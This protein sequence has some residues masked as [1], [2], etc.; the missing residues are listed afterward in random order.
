MSDSYEIQGVKITPAAGGYYDIEHVS[1]SEPERVRGKEKADARAAEIAKAAEA[2]E[3]SMPP[4]GELTT[5]VGGDVIQPGDT[6]SPAE[7]VQERDASGGDP[8]T[9]PLKQP[10]DDG[11]TNSQIKS[12]KAEETRQ[13]LTGTPGVRQAASMGQPT[14]DE[15]DQEIAALK[16]QVGEMSAN[17]SQLM[18]MLQPVVRT[19]EVVEGEDAGAVPLTISRSFTGA[20]DKDSKSALKKAGIGVTEI[21]LE[22]NENIPPTGLFVGHNGR[23]YMIKPGEPVEVPDFIIGILD[24]AITSAPIVDS[25]SQKVLG[26]RNRS[27]YPYRKV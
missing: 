26:Y 14:G 2:P 3:G 13:V 21:V 8:N 24:D 15:K 25:K 16:A 6:R 20:M 19:V 17:F 18:K 1:L 12:E 11:K 27:K 22:E 9:D 10:E 23:S 4:Q 7:R 5:G